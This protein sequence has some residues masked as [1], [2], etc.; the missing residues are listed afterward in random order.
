MVNRWAALSDLDHARANYAKS[1]LYA[2]HHPP[3]LRSVDEA[4]RPLEEACELLEAMTEEA[5]PKSVFEKV[6]K[7]KWKCVA[8][9]P[10]VDPNIAGIPLGTRQMLCQLR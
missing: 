1:M 6:F 3:Y 7:L 10:Q 8:A 5:N 4:G 9:V 2:R